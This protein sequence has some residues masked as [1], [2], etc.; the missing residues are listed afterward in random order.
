LDILYQRDQPAEGRKALLDLVA[1]KIDPSRFKWKDNEK[2]IAQTWDYEHDIL[3]KKI[4]DKFQSYI[5][6]WMNSSAGEA[7]AE[8]L[9]TSRY[10]FS[11]RNEFFFADEN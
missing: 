1:S 7:F 8:M 5:D 11:L 9:I 3:M 10:Y 4:E 6:R 2:F